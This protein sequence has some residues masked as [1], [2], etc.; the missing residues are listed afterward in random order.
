[1]KTSTSFD[2]ITKIMKP[3]GINELMVPTTLTPEDISKGWDAYKEVYHLL[4]NINYSHDDG[5]TVITVSCLEQSIGLTFWNKKD[6]KSET[7]SFTLTSDMDW[8]TIENSGIN[9]LLES[10]CGYS[11]SIG[12]DGFK[13]LA[14]T[15]VSGLISKLTIKQTILVFAEIAKRKLRNSANREIKD[16][17]IVGTTKEEFTIKLTDL[18]VASN[19]FVIPHLGKFNLTKSEES[20]IVAG[21]IKSSPLKVTIETDAFNKRTI[22]MM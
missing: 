4:G 22:S 10:F 9:E 17:R 3:F 6:K 5:K 18:V 11:E 13:H 14:I 1:M 16:G 21:V 19:R 20:V 8:D 12:E 7:K 2:Y 15:F